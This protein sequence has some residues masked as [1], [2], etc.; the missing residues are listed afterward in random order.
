LQQI[1]KLAELLTLYQNRLAQNKKQ[2]L[3]LSPEKL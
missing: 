2:K 1:I 3:Q